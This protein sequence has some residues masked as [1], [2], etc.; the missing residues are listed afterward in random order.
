M[1]DKCNEVVQQ[2][3]VDL[4]RCFIGDDAVF[5]DLRMHTANK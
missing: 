4:Q 2:V 3:S 1:V 5:V